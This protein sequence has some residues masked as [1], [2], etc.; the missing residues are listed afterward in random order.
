MLLGMFRIG[1]DFVVYLKVTIRSKRDLS[2]QL[3][4]GGSF[5]DNSGK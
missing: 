1:N 3:G 4:S 5:F 2:E